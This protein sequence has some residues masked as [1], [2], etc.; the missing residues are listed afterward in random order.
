MNKK[1]RPHQYLHVRIST[2]LASVVKSEALK[3]CKT[4]SQI[5][6]DALSPFLSKS[7]DK[8]PLT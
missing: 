8:T 4:K 1:Q 5:F 6:Q 3:T 2:Q 7:G